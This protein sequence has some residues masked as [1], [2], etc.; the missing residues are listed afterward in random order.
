MRCVQPRPHAWAR[1]YA[2]RVMICLA[3]PYTLSEIY[4]LIAALESHGQ[5]LHP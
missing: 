2:D 4:V 3:R 1:E 5:L